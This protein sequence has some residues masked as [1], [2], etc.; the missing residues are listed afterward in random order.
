MSSPADAGEYGLVAPRAHSGRELARRCRW[1][2]VFPFASRS[3]ASALPAGVAAASDP[4]RGH[5]HDDLLQCQIRS[6]QSATTKAGTHFQRRD[7]APVRLW[8]DASG[9]LPALQPFDRRTGTIWNHSAT[10]CLNAPDPTA[11]T[12]RSRNSKEHGSHRPALQNTC[13]AISTMPHFR[14]PLVERC[15][16]ISRT[17]LSSLLRPEA[18]GTYA[19]GA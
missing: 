15:M 1:Q 4:S 17:A 3:F 14:P 11:S 18:Y 8:G 2:L 13:H 7:A 12:T 10:S 9:R 6:P 19:C 5:R 16:Q